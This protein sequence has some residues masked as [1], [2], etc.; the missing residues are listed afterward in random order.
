MLARAGNA[1]Q[2]PV[3]NVGVD[4]PCNQRDA[5]P[6]LYPESRLHLNKR[7]LASVVYLAQ[8]GTAHIVLQRAEDIH[9]PNPYDHRR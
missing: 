7:L 6:V 4:W 1:L 5:Q 2:A 3:S 9:G 8:G